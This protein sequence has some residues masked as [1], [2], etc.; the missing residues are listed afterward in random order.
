MHAIICARASAYSALVPPAQSMGHG[1]CTYARQPSPHNA[2]KLNA[3]PNRRRRNTA[4]QRSVK[5]NG[6][7][8]SG[9]HVHEPLVKSAR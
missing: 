8:S 5:Q 6:I 3:P 4:R 1:T 7:A 2:A 9:D